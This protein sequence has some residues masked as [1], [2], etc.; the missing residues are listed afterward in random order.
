MERPITSLEGGVVSKYQKRKVIKPTLEHETTLHVKRPRIE[1][2]KRRVVLRQNFYSKI[3]LPL[4]PPRRK[5][6]SQ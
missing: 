2:Q 4:W 3:Q 6:Q 1:R 5:V